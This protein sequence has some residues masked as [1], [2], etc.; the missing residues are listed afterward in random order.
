[1]KQSVVIAGG[2][3][4]LHRG[5]IDHIKKAAELGRLTVI[6]QSDE[7]LERKKGYFLLPFEDRMAVISSI[8]GVSVVTPNID[9]DGTCAETLKLVKPEIFAKGGD[10]TPDNM[11]QNEIET[12]KEIGCEIVYGV[13]DLLN[14]SS[15]IVRRLRNIFKTK[16]TW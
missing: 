1:V 14:S 12:C 16:F 5:H 9:K 8:K 3:D 10:R 7:I 4:P 6:V 15:D 11:P 13:G 2:F